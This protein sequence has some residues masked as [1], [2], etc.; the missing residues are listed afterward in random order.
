MYLRAARDHRLGGD[1]D[2]LAVAVA[3][4]AAGLP[5][6]EDARRDVPRKQ[7]VMD[8]EV[9]P[10]G[11]CLREAKRGAARHAHGLEA[12]EEQTNELEGGATTPVVV[13]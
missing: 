5:H 8:E 9:E 13:T 2:G 3:D 11:R 6:E 1:S 7:E 10:A 12:G 4:R